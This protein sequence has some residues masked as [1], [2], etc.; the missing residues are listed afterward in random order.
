MACVEVDQQNGPHADIDVCAQHLS[1]L[2]ISPADVAQ[3]IQ[4]TSSIY[5]YH[6]LL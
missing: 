3:K 1:V 2:P 5:K 4:P 6:H